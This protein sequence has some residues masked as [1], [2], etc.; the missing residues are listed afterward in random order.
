MAVEPA[1]G[2]QQAVGVDPAGEAF[3][4]VER[5][6]QGFQV[7]IVDPQQRGAQP[8]GAL[9]LF[10]VVDLDQHVHAPIES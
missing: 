5:N 9:E 10:G 2:N 6:F 1:F 7:A 4:H 8:V 3:A